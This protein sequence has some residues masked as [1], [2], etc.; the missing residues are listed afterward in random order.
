MKKM[1]KISIFTYFMLDSGP[2]VAIFIISATLN[3]YVRQRV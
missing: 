2:T 1:E 3:Q